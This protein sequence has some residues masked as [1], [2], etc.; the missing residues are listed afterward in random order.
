[1]IDDIKEAVLT[2]KERPPKIPL[3]S[4]EGQS[5]ESTW[6]VAEECWGHYH[7]D[8]ISM[9]TAYNRLCEADEAS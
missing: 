4:L 9:E 7:P 1:M 6:N 2:R 3:S 8:R 5:Y